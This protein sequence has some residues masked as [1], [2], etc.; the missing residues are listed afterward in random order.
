M[1]PQGR[2]LALIARSYP[3]AWHASHDVG[4]RL[5]P[6]LPGVQTIVAYGYPSGPRSLDLATSLPRRVLI[7]PVT[8]EKLKTYL[9][10]YY[11]I[12]GKNGSL[13]GQARADVPDVVV[14]DETC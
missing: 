8:I 9:T 1:P 12:Q 6:R 7:E 10:G 2:V 14:Q 13:T 5:L 3:S 11:T 4:G